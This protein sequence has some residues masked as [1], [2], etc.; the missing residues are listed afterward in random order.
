LAISTKCR[1]EF[2]V[3]SIKAFLAWACAPHNMNTT[4]LE[5]WATVW[6]N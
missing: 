4:D 2:P 5:L 3:A 1:P 6:T